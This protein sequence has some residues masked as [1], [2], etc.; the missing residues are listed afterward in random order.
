MSA[1]STPAASHTKAAEAHDSAANL[2]RMAAEQH[3]KG[4]NK[5]GLE[6]A[7]KA[8]KASEMAQGCCKDAHSKSKGAAH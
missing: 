4:D 7:E 6:H 5:A 3:Q 1:N 8:V 2:H